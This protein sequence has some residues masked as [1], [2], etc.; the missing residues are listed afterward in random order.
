VTAT[1]QVR[2]LEDMRIATFFDWFGSPRSILALGVGK[3]SLPARETTERLLSLDAED[4]DS[5]DLSS[6]GRFDAVF[7]VNLAAPWRLLARTARVADALFLEAPYWQGSR[8]AEVEGR[9]GGEV[10]GSFLLTRPALLEELTASGWAIRH[11]TD[12]S[13]HRTRPRLL[14]GCVRP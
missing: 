1:A 12:L 2:V 4:L 3:G 6:Y 8:V 9:L 13:R 5:V 11:Q 7:C 10:D 14:L